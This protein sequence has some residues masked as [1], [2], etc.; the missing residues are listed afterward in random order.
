V[1]IINAVD[2]KPPV[3][4]CM[5]MLGLAEDDMKFRAWMRMADITQGELAP[6]IGLSQAMLS[7]IYNGYVPSP[8]VMQRIAVITKGAVLPNDF[9]D[10]LPV[11]RKNKA[12]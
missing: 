3:C 1:G 8:A 5:G 4:I 11:S 7:R 12:A 6:K 10:D 2:F 9:F